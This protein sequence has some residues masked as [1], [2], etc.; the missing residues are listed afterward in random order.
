M[1]DSSRFKTRVVTWLLWEI[2]RS[3]IQQKMTAAGYDS[4][5]ELLTP[6]GQKVELLQ[7]EKKKEKKAQNKIT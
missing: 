2:C 5:L 1:S 4:S 6:A 7:N 3:F